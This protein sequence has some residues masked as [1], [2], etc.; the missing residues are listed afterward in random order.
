MYVLQSPLM[1]GAFNGITNY[2]QRVLTEKFL[3]EKTIAGELV[4]IPLWVAFSAP[5]FGVIADKFGKRATFL[6][7]TSAFS[8][9][10]SMLLLQLPTGEKNL[11]LVVTALSLLG[12]FLSS[13]CAF[14]YPTIPLVTQPY[15][16]STAFAISFSSKNAGSL[17]GNSRWG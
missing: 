14:L 3:I 4:S 12:L 6:C 7:L 17:K 8:L 16:H 5:L 2:L 15:I 13:M 9:V 11:I 10:S 1:F